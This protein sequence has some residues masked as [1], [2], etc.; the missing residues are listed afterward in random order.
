MGV[1]ELN[2][3][4]IVDQLTQYFKHHKS[5]KEQLEEPLSYMYSSMNSFFIYSEIS[6][7]IVHE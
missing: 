3:F 1:K 5:N 4:Y 2:N 6:F 7:I